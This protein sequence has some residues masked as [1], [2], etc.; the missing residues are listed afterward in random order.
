MFGSMQEQSLLGRY[1]VTAIRGPI[2]TGICRS[3]G[4][5]R[6]FHCC[7]S[8]RPVAEA[9]QGFGPY[10]ARNHPPNP[11]ECVDFEETRSG[12]REGFRR[13]AKQNRKFW[14]FPLH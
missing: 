9:T 7:S 14:Q 13:I 10:A 2:P 3:T 4:F 6:S 5:S 8:G 1:L 11:V 12:G